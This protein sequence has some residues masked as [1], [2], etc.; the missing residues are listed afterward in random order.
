MFRGLDTRESGGSATA[1]PIVK[2]DERAPL[3][4][5]L[6]VYLRSSAPDV[7]RERQRAVLDFVDC[8]ESAEIVDDVPVV[9]W[10]KQA[11]AP[12][13][14]DTE[15]AVACYDEF[16]ER[17]GA[18]ALEPFFEERSATGRANRVIV[19]P[20]ICIAVRDGDE[21]TGLYPHW[22]EGVHHS[23]EDCLTALSTGEPVENV[24]AHAATDRP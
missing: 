24:G 5:E 17:V 3:N 14:P 1:T 19:F 23:I 9:R 13:N 10:P 12:A 22:N 7:A 16:V 8:L 15:V 20:V 2:I 11:R 21:L 6:T 18:R 4:G